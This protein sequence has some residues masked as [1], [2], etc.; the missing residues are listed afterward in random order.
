MD[1]PDC[2]NP[3][4]PE[5]VACAGCGRSLTSCD[6]AAEIGHESLPS[7][8]AAAP[9]VLRP[10]PRLA[11]GTELGRRY[12][13]LRLLGS[14]GMGQVYLARDGE[15]DREVALKLIRPDLSENPTILGRFKREVQ[16]SSKVTHRNVLR[17]HDLSESDG[18]FFLTMEYVRGRDLATLLRKEGL[19]PIER[20]VRIFREVCEGLAAAHDQQVLHRDLK[21][22]N[23]LVDEADQ[24]RLTD[25]GLAKSLEAV[26][27]T[28]TGAL[29]GTPDYISPEQIK[30]RPAD[31]RSDIYALGV[32]LYQL[33]TG[34]MPFR[35]QTSWE[36]ALQRLQK[37]PTPASRLNP[38]T[39]KYLQQILERCM[40]V[41]P[42][43]R[44]PAV[45]AILADL[46]HAAP[47]ASFVHGL[48][49]RRKRLL[50]PA[51]AVVLLFLVG[52]MGWRY[53]HSLRQGGQPVRGTGAAAESPGAVVAVVPF[54]NRTGQST[55]DWYGEGL[56]RLIMDDLAQSRHAQVISA[57]TVK[58]LQSKS[59]S[60]RDLAQAAAAAGIGYLLTGEIVST[61]GGLTVAARLT[62]ARKGREAAARRVDSLT[63][64]SLI[65]VADTIASAT[66]K[67]LGLPPAEGVDVFA[68]DFVAR[69]P[70]AY[71]AY[72]KGLQAWT[73]YR[74]D[75]A[76]A[77]FR[78]ALR[79][80]GDF[81]MAR[82][83]LAQ[84][85]ADTGRMD[86]AR[87]EIRKAAAESGRLSDR[88][89]RYIRATEAYFSTQDE[90]AVKEYQDLLKVYP[91]EIEGREL[92]ATILTDLGRNK[93]AIEQL[94]INAQMEPEHRVT[95]SLLG[96]AYL[97][98]GDFNQ[99]VLALRRYVELEPGS[100]N[101][102]HL[103]GD[104]YR[105][106][107]EF[108]L[109]AAE[110]GKALEL[111]PTFHYSSVSLAEVDIL[112]DQWS[113][114]ETRLTKLMGDSTVLPRNRLDAGFLLAS[115][116]RAQGRL[117]AAARVLADLAAPLRQ[118]QVREAMA[119]SM[120]GTCMMELGRLREA[121]TLIDESVRRSPKVPTRYLFA[122]GLLE[123]RE[124]KPAAAR[125]TASEILKSALPPGNP[126][127]TEEKAAAFLSGLAWLQEGQAKRATEDLSR[128]VAL[129]GYEYSIYRLAL[130]RAYLEDGRLQEA[131][132]A[133]RQA[134]APLDPAKPRADLNLD[135]WR[136]AL[137][138]A[139]IQE[140]MGQHSDA[141][142]GARAVLNHWSH[143][144]PE[145]SD[146]NA[147][148]RLAGAMVS[149]GPG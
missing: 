49:M 56:A 107:S 88:E 130:A 89:A 4:P 124:R 81:T 136:A 46:E 24:V 104:A 50:T 48:R 132:A 98:D 147:A 21:P 95:W 45:R 13:I 101:G 47:Q 43:L 17:V 93:E 77:G 122:R 110:Y 109:A 58:I 92:L 135:R 113:G 38:K 55:L 19:L 137:L 80:A 10:S 67:G 133:A 7:T 117:R 131:M 100:P 126:D 30:G 18:V 37:Q 103:L 78:E 127:R 11:E 25:F 31:E 140:K 115:L 65:G 39:P 86:E 59:A 83:R 120:R 111:D 9:V 23:I 15:L 119:L 16:L 68:A 116:H 44:Y 22:Q 29:M 145:L 94:R 12:R 57:D 97:A 118:E 114:A 128:S 20:V 32:I 27:L 106:Q 129:S 34:S 33:L 102:H 105:A 84:V 63:A 70:S 1:C 51:V 142:A 85:L 6:G 36:V 2:G 42:S 5:A 74:Y 71:E 28:E 146:L 96:S 139:E 82:Y 14:G 69:N 121:R 141:R 54:E 144:D 64:D 72:L 91:H 123:L 79:A 90:A 26:G 3:N 143:A 108:D 73:Y 40:A 138:L 149:A 53:A 99:A 41:D 35:G 75:E 8:L 112:R 60:P 52:W 134:A 66:R 125:E 148:R 62:D 87:T 76:E 61:P